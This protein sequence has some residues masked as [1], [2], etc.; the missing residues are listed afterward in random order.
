MTRF[1][2][3]A[4]IVLAA[5]ASSRMGRPK[6]LLPVGERTM[7][8]AAVAPHLEAG[9]G[10]VVVVLGCE[11]AAVARGAALAEHPRLEIVVNRR[12]REG[13]ASSLR[14]GLDRCADADAVLVALG[15]Q[16]GVTADR[17][18]LIAAAWGPGV[19]LVVP[20]TARSRAGHP[21]LFARSLWPE[22]R[23]LRGDVGAREV[24]LRHLGRALRVDLPPLP[25][26]DDDADYRRHLA[27]EPAAESGLEEAAIMGPC[28]RRRSRSRS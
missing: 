21:V 17:V 20:R 10:R 24:V 12:W 25:D 8:A 7:L 5:G 2:R 11:A 15:D 26:L 23:A 18:A 16:P 1:P 6:M 9:I 28:T 13:M 4:T 22:L 27:G 14:R 3:L 19:P